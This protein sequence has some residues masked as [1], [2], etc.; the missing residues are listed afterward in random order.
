MRSKYRTN[1]VNIVIDDFLRRQRSLGREHKL[2]ITVEICAGDHQL[3]SA[4]LV[5]VALVSDIK[6]SHEYD[7][8]GEAQLT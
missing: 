5:L 4:T 6:D 8:A 3:L 1:L 7:E 2:A